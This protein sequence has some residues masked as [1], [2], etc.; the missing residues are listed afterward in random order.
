MLADISPKVVASAFLGKDS[1]M[2]HIVLQKHI[3]GFLGPSRERCS[4]CMQAACRQVEPALNRASV[5]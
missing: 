2:K 3:E 5:S 1:P 4:F